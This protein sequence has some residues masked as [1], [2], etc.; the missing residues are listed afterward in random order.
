MEEEIIK[1]LEIE[2]PKKKRRIFLPIFIVFI[3]LI[4]SGVGYI[5]YQYRQDITQESLEPKDFFIKDEN[6]ELESIG[7]LEQA[8][9]EIDN[10]QGAS[11]PALEFRNK[12]DPSTLVYYFDHDGKLLI[13]NLSAS[14]N[15][16]TSD[17]SSASTGFF[18]Y[19]GSTASH[20]TSGIID[21]IYATFINSTNV[22]STYYGN[23]SDWYTID[24]FLNNTDTDTTI[25]N[26]SGAG[27][28]SNVAY[29]DYTNS[30]NFNVT[31]RDKRS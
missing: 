7:N 29:M 5:Y 12:S 4:S 26:C 16:V 22:S 11:N 8:R 28:C 13:Y 31:G 15:I 25:G 6:G 27:S 19:L 1:P 10:R 20:I 21:T 9:E 23:G 14:G 30:G 18:T 3:L 24:Q 17:N 2:K